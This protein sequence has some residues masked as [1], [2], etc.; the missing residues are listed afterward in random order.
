MRLR[1][2]RYDMQIIPENS[3]DEAYIEEVLGL[4]Q[5]RQAV[6]AIRVNV[7]G[8]S[9]IACLQI[10]KDDVIAKQKDVVK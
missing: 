4:K 7:A 6:K 5:D 10:G 8:L 2:H 1:V 3:V 9:S